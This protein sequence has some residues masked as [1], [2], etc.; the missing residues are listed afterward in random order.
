MKH[1]KKVW[2]DKRLLVEQWI[3]TYK[4]VS[5]NVRDEIKEDVEMIY[6]TTTISEHIREEGREE[7]RIEGEIKGEIKILEVLYEEGF[8]PLAEFE[9]RIIPLR[10]KLMELIKSEKK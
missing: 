4:K 3:D 9:K 8:L 7:G 2:N 6:P 5:D 10:K 1:Y